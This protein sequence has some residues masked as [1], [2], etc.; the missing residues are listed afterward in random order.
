MATTPAAAAHSTWP[1]AILDVQVWEVGM[2]S[3]VFEDLAIFL[4]HVFKCFDD[5]SKKKV[6]EKRGNDGC[7]PQ[8]CSL[9][10]AN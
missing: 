1:P 2:V 7:E 3:K 4:H 8:E 10:A 9:F 6:F 5:K